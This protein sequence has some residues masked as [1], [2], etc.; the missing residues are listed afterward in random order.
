MKTIKFI[1]LFLVLFFT[2]CS[3]KPFSKWSAPELRVAI[4]AP[5]HNTY[6]EI[7]ESLV[8]SGKYFVVDRSSGLHA[9][10]EEQDFNQTDRVGAKEKYAKMGKL[11]GVGSVVVGNVSCMPHRH[12]FEAVFA[13][14]SE[15]KLH[16]FL[17]ST[18]TGEVIAAAKDTVYANRDTSRKTEPTPSWDSVV[19]K[20]NNAIPKYFTD[21]KY[22][23]E[24]QKFRNGEIDEVNQ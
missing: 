8:S 2:A 12:F 17:I 14:S 23:A 15:C 5:D 11:Y 18:S 1:L 24:M 22:T 21:I 19:E 7:Q 6:S 13:P 3:S 4:V 16:I 10:M 20:L 9:A